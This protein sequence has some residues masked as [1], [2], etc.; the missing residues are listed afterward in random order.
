[1]LL[2]EADESLVDELCALVC[3]Q[4]LDSDTS[5]VVDVF[6]N[7]DDTVTRLGLGSEVVKVDGAVVAVFDDKA[8]LLARSAVLLFMFNLGLICACRQ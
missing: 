5:L 6:E 3:V 8:P 7:A 1:M 4:L 2:A